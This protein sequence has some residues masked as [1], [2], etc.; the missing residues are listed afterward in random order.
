MYVYLYNLND[1]L[2][3]FLLIN[4]YIYVYASIC[5]LYIINIVFF[6]AHANKLEKKRMKKEGEQRGKE[7]WRANARTDKLI[8][9]SHFNFT[10]LII[11]IFFLLL[12]QRLEAQ[13]HLDI[14][15]FVIVNWSSKKRK[16]EKSKKKERKN[17]SID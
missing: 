17:Y 9:L 14:Y 10:L 16:L 5:I 12:L 8:R 4:Y 13:V 7:E 1:W 6:S 2:Y 3:I 15:V 11:Q